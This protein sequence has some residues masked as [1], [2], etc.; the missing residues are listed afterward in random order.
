[1]GSSQI[2]V[3]TAVARSDGSFKASVALPAGTGKQQLK[4]LGTSANGKR[5]ELAKVVLIVA[6][7][8]VTDGPGS[9]LAKPVLLT[10]AG[11]I[12]L[13]TWLVLEI[14]GWRGRRSTM[15]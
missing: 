6:S 9:G 4:V 10:L 12:P 13:A 7:H 3:G 5:A 1:L 14:L 8:K 15:P 2:V 11:V